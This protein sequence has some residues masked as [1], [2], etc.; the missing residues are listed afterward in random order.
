MTWISHLFTPVQHSWIEF[1][2]Q[3]C[4]QVSWKIKRE[5]EGVK[6]EKALW[7]LKQV[8]CSIRVNKVF[9][10]NP[11]LWFLGFPTLD[12][13][14]NIPCLILIVYRDIF[15]PHYWHGQG[16]LQCSFSIHNCFPL[17][18]CLLPWSKNNVLVSFANFGASTILN[19]IWTKYMRTHLTNSTSCS[20]GWRIQF[21]PT[22]LFS[23][24]LTPKLLT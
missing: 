8:F 4:L 10:Q 18:V 20:C 14:Y 3:Y 5:N 1:S 15:I 2:G 6:W 21:T 16:W 12:R 17:V 19:F 22:K 13:P 7:L 11:G 23:F 9:D 24:N